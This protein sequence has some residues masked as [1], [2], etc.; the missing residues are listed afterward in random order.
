MKHVLLISVLL[1][2]AYLNAQDLS[3]K[4]EELS[5]PQFVE[6]VD[7]SS[8]TIILPIGVFEKHGPHMPLGTDLYTAREISIRAA[9][10]DYTVVFP[11]Y[12]FS[13]INEA[14]HQPGTIAYSPELIWEVLQQTLD[15]LSRNGFKKIIIF[16]GHGGNSAFLN[17]FGMAQLS[18]ERDYALYWFQPSY[19]SEVLKK[20]ESLTQKDPYDQHAGNRET[21][22]VKA[23]VPDLVHPEKAGQQSGRDLERLNDLPHVYTGIWWYASYPN[24][25]SGDGSKANAEAGEL[26]LNSVVNQ[27]VETIKNIKA[28]KN[29]PELQEQFFREAENPLGTNQK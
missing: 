17:Y 5:A 29:V 7:K 23:I 21:S 3:V 11:W 19:D 20:A 14:R 12:Y 6:A 2:S 18:E 10:K 28:D 8:K 1:C 24:H 25:Y 4:M 15:E 16:N 26:I 9:E 27:F 22:M 13:Q